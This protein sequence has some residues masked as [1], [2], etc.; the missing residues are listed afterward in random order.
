MHNNVKT[1][2]AEMVGHRVAMGGWMGRLGDFDSF[3]P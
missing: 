2:K 3:A 1:K